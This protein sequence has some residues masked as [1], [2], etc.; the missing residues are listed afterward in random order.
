MPFTKATKAG[1]NKQLIINKLT[2][3]CNQQGFYF[4]GSGVKVN[5][6]IQEATESL[7]KEWAFDLLLEELEE[8]GQVDQ[9]P[10]D[11]VVFCIYPGWKFFYF[12][13]S[14]CDTSNPMIYRY[15]GGPSSKIENI[16]SLEVFINDREF[17]YA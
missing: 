13:E 15:V 16:S 14:E 3:N 7:L 4:I 12:R 8:H 17:Y 11:A 2:S 10:N 1:M 6:K 5:G 9:L